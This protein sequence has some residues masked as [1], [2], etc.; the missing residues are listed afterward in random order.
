MRCE[1]CG[2]D[3]RIPKGRTIAEAKR[4]TVVTVKRADGTEATMCRQALWTNAQQEAEGKV[5]GPDGREREDAPKRKRRKPKRRRARVPTSV[6][7][8]LEVLLEKQ[9]E[10]PPGKLRLR[11]S[12]RR[13]DV[14]NV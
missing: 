2:A 9:G 12:A 6:R 13:E 3:H 14:S 1:H 5:R 11:A 7:V 8:A 4:M 10:A